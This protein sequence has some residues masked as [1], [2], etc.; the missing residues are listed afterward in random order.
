[1]LDEGGPFQ[2]LG[3]QIRWVVVGVDLEHLVTISGGRGSLSRST[4]RAASV[5]HWGSSETKRVSEM[6]RTSKLGSA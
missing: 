1:M 6:K 2:H 5:S 4:S 3:E